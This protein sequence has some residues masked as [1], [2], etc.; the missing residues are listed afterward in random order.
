M[1]VSKKEE[2]DILLR[3]LFCVDIQ[4]QHDGDL[5]ALSAFIARKRTELFGDYCKGVSVCKLTRK[6]LLK[7]KRQ[8]NY[9]SKNNYAFMYM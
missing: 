1:K 2:L 8:K 4:K 7:I 9:K 5:N 6:R 3:E